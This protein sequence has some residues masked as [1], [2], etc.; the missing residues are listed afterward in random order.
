MDVL[1]PDKLLTAVTQASKNLNLHHVRS[2][3]TT[4]SRY[5]HRNSSLLSEA[6][7]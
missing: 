3:Q 2:E 7:I 1:D 4:R 5:E 6:T